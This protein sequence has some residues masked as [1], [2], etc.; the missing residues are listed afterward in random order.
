M[1]SI[2]ATSWA[3]Q[4]FAGLVKGGAVLVAL[5]QVKPKSDKKWMLGV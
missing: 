4:E 1:W 3:E 2:I 5:G